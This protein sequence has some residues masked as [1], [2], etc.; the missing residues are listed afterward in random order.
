MEYFAAV[1]IGATKTTASLCSREGILARVYQLTRKTGDNGAVPRQVDFLIGH[2]CEQA[3]ISRG[4]IAAVGVSTASPFVKKRGKLALAAP[5][6]CGGLASARREAVNDWKEIPLEEELAEICP[7][8]RIA[9]DCVSA[10][11]A[12][13]S[14]GAGRGEDD[15]LYV[16]WSTGIGGG[17][18][19]D[20]HPLTG[21]NGNALHLGHVAM[22]WEYSGGPLCGCGGRAH[23]EA[24]TSGLAIAREY[25]AESPEVFRRCREGE[26]RAGE[27]IHR[28]AVVMAVGLYNAV[29]LLDTRLI[30]VG[31]SVSRNW[32]LLEPLVTGEFYRG[33]P[34]LTREVVFR[35]SELDQYLGDMAGLSL[36]MPEG[37]ISDWQ[38]R[39]PW[40]RSPALVVLEPD[41]GTGG[42]R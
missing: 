7:G 39:R 37:W 15:L 3:G 33:F 10:A 1:D 20:G 27:L 19:V 31:G 5:N 21:K 2:V 34:V 22:S 16:T 29:A 14:F 40:Q 32:D 4:K 8:L 12:E 24:M 17:A 23:L 38:L 42:R 13:R 36:V 18:F 25:G 6:I 28:I 11:A 35:H 26:E 30:V 9:N 41:V